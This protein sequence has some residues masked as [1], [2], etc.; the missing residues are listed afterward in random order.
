MAN[1]PVRPCQ[2]LAEALR[3]MS[4]NY[5]DECWRTIENAFEAFGMMRCASIVRRA[6]SPWGRA[7]PRGRFQRRVRLR[8]AQLRRFRSSEML[9]DDDDTEFYACYDKEA[10]GYEAAGVRYMRSRPT[11]NGPEVDNQDRGG[12]NG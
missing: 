10:D 4:E 2:T 9:V 5:A 11:S 7:Y 3:H 8:I 1:A 6:M 12:D